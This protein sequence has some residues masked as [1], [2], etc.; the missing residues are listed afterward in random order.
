[1]SWNRCLSGHSLRGGSW[2]RTGTDSGTSAADERAREAALRRLVPEVRTALDNAPDVRVWPSSWHD[3]ERVD[4]FYHSGSVLARDR[5]LPRVQGRTPRPGRT[6]RRGRGRSDRRRNQARRKRPRVAAHAGRRRGPRPPA[7]RRRGHARSCVYRHR[8]PVTAR[9]PSPN[10]SSLPPRRRI[11]WWSG[12]RSGLAWATRQ[13]GVTSGSP[14]WTPASCPGRAPG[15]LGSR[16][17]DQDT[18]ADIEDPDQIKVNA[19]EHEIVGFARSVRRPRH[20]QYQGVIRSIT[21]ASDIVVEPRPWSRG[22]RPGV[23]PHPADS[24]CPGTLTPTSSAC[25]SRLLHPEERSLPRLPDPLGRAPEPAWR[26]RP[27]GRRGQPIGDHSL[28]ASRVPSGASA[29]ARWLA[30]GSAAP[31]SATTGRGSMFTRLVKK[32]STP[33]PT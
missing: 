24:R 9:P 10:R 15:H 5:D 2:L 11:Q 19:M 32:S 28:L 33:T 6:A 8:F 16:V 3:D 4:Y 1:M 17:Y 27:R 25:T 12:M 30:T 26:R 7:R 20:V 22:L 23:P 21:P 14:L 18:S 13:P 31:G 29:S